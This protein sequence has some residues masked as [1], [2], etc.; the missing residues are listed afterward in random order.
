MAVRWFKE[1]DVRR[2][3]KRFGVRHDVLLVGKLQV[4][5]TLDSWEIRL[6]LSL[7]F[8]SRDSLSNAWLDF[9][10]GI[11]VHCNSLRLPD[12]RTVPYRLWGEGLPIDA[13]QDF[14]GKPKDIPLTL[15]ERRIPAEPLLGVKVRC[16]WDKIGSITVT[17]KTVPGGLVKKQL[18]LLKPFDVE[19]DNSRIQPPTSDK[20][21]SQT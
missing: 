6:P 10:G 21:G 7:H 18:K 11:G 3:W 9:S 16:H 5:K 4:S 13:G 14:G 2:Y 17:G 15:V 20:G 8:E 12:G 19:V 1:R